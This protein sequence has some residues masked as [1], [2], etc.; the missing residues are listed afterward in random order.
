MRLSPAIPTLFLLI[1]TS[2][3]VALGLSNCSTSGT[4]APR[5]DRP[6]AI[7]TVIDWVQQNDRVQGV[8]RIE[9]WRRWAA[10]DIALWLNSRGTDANPD[11]DCFQPNSNKRVDISLPTVESLVELRIFTGWTSINDYRTA[12]LNGINTYRSNRI[13]RYFGGYNRFV[14]GIAT[15]RSIKNGLTC[16]TRTRQ[17]RPAVT[18]ENCI[19]ELYIYFDGSQDMDLRG[20]RHE[21]VRWTREIG[22]PAVPGQPD[23]EDFVVSWKLIPC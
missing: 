20:F 11:A 23:Q 18:D 8:W 10:F 9:G 15:R 12:L 2:P 17:G 3:I 4:L 21:E 6:A 1:F 13:Q 22:L 7:Q 14:V 19:E 16:A 5:Q